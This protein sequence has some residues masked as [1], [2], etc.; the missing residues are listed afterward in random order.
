MDLL[1]AYCGLTVDLL[2]CERVL[3]ALWKLLRAVLS[4]SLLISQ[5]GY[6]HIWGFTTRQNHDFSESSGSLLVRICFASA[7]EAKVPLNMARVFSVKRPEARLLR[8]AYI[9]R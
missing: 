5:D 4:A 1:W 6:R 3:G 9:L 8:I 7:F 2:L